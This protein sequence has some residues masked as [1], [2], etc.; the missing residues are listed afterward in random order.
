MSD[1]GKSNDVVF[2]VVDG[3]TLAVK[4]TKSAGAN[5]MAAVDEM[6]RLIPLICVNLTTSSD[7]EFEALLRKV[8]WAREK[9]LMITAYVDGVADL[10]KLDRY[11]NNE[12]EG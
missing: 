11:N 6:R 12:K 7:D 9:T 1:V 5:A 8:R 3:D 4:L 2:N 10:V